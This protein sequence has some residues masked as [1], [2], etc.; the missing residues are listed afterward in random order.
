MSRL[1]NG[2]LNLLS[3]WAAWLTGRLVAFIPKVFVWSR[4][5]FTRRVI[6]YNEQSGMVLSSV[7]WL[8]FTHS[9]FLPVEGSVILSHFHWLRPNQMQ[10]KLQVPKAQLK[11]K[12]YCLG[13]MLLGENMQ[14]FTTLISDG[15]WN[16]FN[17]LLQGSTP[18]HF[19][20]FLNLEGEGVRMALATF[21]W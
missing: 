14:V 5:S 1:V 6:I 8:W 4:Q 13:S 21:C 2:M 18:T 9:C 10:L 12:S 17:P 20:L 15:R 7:P 3:C 11:K 19:L 16:G